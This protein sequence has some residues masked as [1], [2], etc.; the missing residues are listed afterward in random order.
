MEQ[1]RNKK[2]AKDILIYG[3]GNIGS[4]L[5]TFLLFPVYT[6]FISPDNLG[7]YN[8][9]FATILLL[10]PFISL[11][12]RDGVFR[13]LID[14]KD[15]N[16]RK[17]VINQSYRMIITMTIIATIIFLVISIFF[18][19]RC[20]YYIFG[21][22]LVMSFYEVETQILR[23]LGLSKLFVVCG[24][25]TSFLILIFSILFVIILKWD[26]E[27]IF[28]ANILARLL[29]LCFIEIKQLI[30][31]KYFSLK[32]N[33]IFITKS[34]LKYC[35]PLILSGSFLWIMANSY[36]YFIEYDLGLYANGLFAVAFKFVTIIEVLSSIIFQA[37]QETSVLQYNAKD[38]DEYY[39]SILNAYIP[40]LTG[41]V[42]TLSFFLKAFYSKIVEAEYESSVKYVYILCVAE[43][44]FA[45]QSFMSAIFHANK[46]TV[47][48]FYLSC[49]S[50]VASIIFNY[51]FIKYLGLTGAAISFGLSFFF[52][53]TCYT[54]S[55]QKFARI[56]FSPN[57]LILSILLLTGGGLV[58]YNTENVFWLI[59][60]W[61]A[62]MSVVYLMLPKHVWHEIM[63]WIVTKYTKTRKVK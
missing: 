47:Q 54:L 38:R 22:L 40:L 33:D 3:I 1:S 16:H 44:G 17:K 27:G 19:I 34:L 8:L 31:R 21:L 11:Q 49:I 36:N 30:A 59:S 51:V 42:I 23:G 25:I 4:K 12:L 48:L 24:I 45:L 55:A 52:L 15:E 2:L 35:L 53:F 62:S 28:L 56:I 60:Y 57:I 63:N 6:F 41:I 46:K 20:G 18:K 43:I 61:L 32:I 10:M 9:S 39:S 26:V 37:W 29:V 14:N 5:I 13:F 58:F 7:Y 50:S